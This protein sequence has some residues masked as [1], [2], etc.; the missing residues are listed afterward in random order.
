VSSS[1][2]AAR[3]LTV[4]MIRTLLTSESLLAL[5]P[6]CSHALP[7]EVTRRARKI[8]RC[9]SCPVALL[10]LAHGYLVNTCEVGENPTRSPPLG[11]SIGPAGD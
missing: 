4:E 9:D 7:E 10:R 8:A 1:G 6:P 11:G 5:A 2:I 3:L